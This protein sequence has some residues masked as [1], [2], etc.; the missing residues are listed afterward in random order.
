MLGASQAMK[1][2]THRERE[3][4]ERA[5][6]LSG[7]VVL[8]PYGECPLRGN[9]LFCGDRQLIDAWRAGSSDNACG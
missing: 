6:S 1:K 8:G 7:V 5:A 2:R 3:R 4:K 9:T